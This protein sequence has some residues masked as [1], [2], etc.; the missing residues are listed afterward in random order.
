MKQQ[1]SALSSTPGDSQNA[2]G[3]DVQSFGNLRETVESLVITV[4]KL[5]QD[6]KAEQNRNSDLK[7]QI[8][9]LKSA[10]KQVDT[11]GKGADSASL[12]AEHQSKFRA[13]ELRVAGLETQS[14]SHESEL[15]GLVATVGKVQ[16]RVEKSENDNVSK[17]R[18]DKPVLAA[19]VKGDA[20][21][22]RKRQ[23][24]GG[25]RKPAAAA[26]SDTMSKAGE[27][28]VQAPSHEEAANNLLDSLSEE[29]VDSNRSVKSQDNS[30]LDSNAAPTAGSQLNGKPVSAVATTTAGSTKKSGVAKISDPS[31]NGAINKN[32]SSAKKPSKG[33]TAGSIK[34]HVSK[35]REIIPGD[36]ETGSKPKDKSAGKVSALLDAKQQVD[37]ISKR[38][39]AGDATVD[40]VPKLPQA[41]A[42]S[43]P[44]E[45]GLENSAVDTTK[46]AQGNPLLNPGQA[47]V[48]QR[49][50]EG[51]SNETD[52]T[53]SKLNSG[54]KADAP[55]SGL[56]ELGSGGGEG[57]DG[58]PEQG[59]FG[60]ER[61]D[62]MPKPQGLEP[63]AI[64]P[65]LLE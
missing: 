15:R 23:A 29:G 9:S 42:D 37:G 7:K 12:G 50:V 49:S 41:K 27:Q 47:E 56:I 11:A 38:S 65:Q 20:E 52:V 55:I 63:P 17:K 51:D 31:N 18:E 36:T 43:Y 33:S 19:E 14:V 64:E 26:S 5:S 46:E 8:E 6:L 57:G 1:L 54:P 22:S 53:K 34:E 28:D 32:E 48:K 2:A 62:P 44:D 16:A 25:A 21:V 13:L 60:Y 30:Q 35:L 10:N 40:D 4:D 3:V 45:V 58:E 61:P 59:M 39:A 24:A